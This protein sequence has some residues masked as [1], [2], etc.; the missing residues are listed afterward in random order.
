MPEYDLMT[1]FTNPAWAWFIFIVTVGGI[2]WCFY[3][4]MSQSKLSVK[5]GGDKIQ[6]T[7]HIW[8]EDIEELNTPIPRWWMQLFIATNIF[9]LVYLVLYP[10][11]A[12]FDG[13]LGWSQVGQYNTEMEVAEKKYGEQYANYLKQDIVNLAKNKDAIKTGGRLFSTYCTQC[14]GTDA[15]GGPGFPNLRDSRWLWGGETEQVK[16]TIS[17]GR[18][19]TMPAW[20]A[21]LGKSG[22]RDVTA[23]VLSLSGRKTSGDL[24]VG[25]EKF[26]QLCV[27]CHTAEGTG[28][29][30]LGA[31]DL[32]DDSW[33]YGS[34]RRIIAK[35]ISE[36]RNGRMPAFGDFLGEGKTHLLAAYVYS[37]SLEE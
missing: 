17:A 18:M 30:A 5:E 36:G 16:Q 23:Y 22:T 10:G 32:T 7:G 24:K 9:G 12:I 19:G 35:S 13:V 31:P 29:I 26:K 11:S 3:L 28:N 37:L 14:H 21:V 8:D 1:D 34:S 6:S 27:A 4:L 20:G 2:F 15:G 33:L 25:E